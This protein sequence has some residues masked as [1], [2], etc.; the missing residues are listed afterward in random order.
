MAVSAVGSVKPQSITGQETA[1]DGRDGSEAGS[2]QEVK[3][4]WNQ[5]P[6]IARG[7][8]ILEYVAQA[9]KEVLPVGIRIEHFS[10]FNPPAHDVMKRA[11]GVYPRSSRHEMPITSST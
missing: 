4:P 7:L 3:V 2:E 1:H 11:R 10:L 9:I 8:G 5:S 6:S